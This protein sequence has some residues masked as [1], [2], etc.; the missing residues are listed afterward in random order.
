[1]IYLN[2]LITSIIINIL[3]Y[4]DDTMHRLYEDDGKYNLIYRL[5][6]IV[7]SDLSMKIMTFILEVLIDYQ[8]E[9]I[10]LKNYLGKKK[11]KKEEKRRNINNPK[12]FKGRTIKKSFQY[13]RIIFYIINIILNIFGW[14]FISCFCAVYHNTQKFLFFDFLSSIPMNIISCLLYCLLYLTLHILIIKVDDSRI[15]K[16]IYKICKFLIIS[17]IIEMV[18][19]FLLAYLAD[20]IFN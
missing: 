7:I 14:Y 3:F 2:S 19:E 15:I 5:P 16:I 4:T 12:D 1:M 11:I 18:I 10:E 17:F 6:K 9:F 13:R 8:E 20:L